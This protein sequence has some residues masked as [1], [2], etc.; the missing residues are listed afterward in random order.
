HWKKP[1]LH[2][3]GSTPFISLKSLPSPSGP[4]GRAHIQNAR[5]QFG[6]AFLTTICLASSP[7]PSHLGAGGRV[8][9]DDHTA[10]EVSVLH[11]GF[12]GDTGKGGV[13]VGLFRLDFRGLGD[14]D[15]VWDVVCVDGGVSFGVCSELG[16]TLGVGFALKKA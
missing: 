2:S 10:L 8:K 7:W 1:H 13:G 9:S 3:P 15:E 4:T 5:P 14:G 12:S 6:P 11:G 16:G